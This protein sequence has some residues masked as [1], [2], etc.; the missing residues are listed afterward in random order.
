[1]PAGLRRR[2]VRGP[3]RRH[4]LPGGARDEGF[5]LV[6]VLV[7][8]ALMTITMTA[9]TTF[10][11]AT[12]QAANQQS[13][14]QV[15]AQLAQDAIEQAR[16]LKGS[17]IITGRAQ[18]GGTNTCATPVAGVAPYLADV[19]EWDHPSGTAQLPT[20]PKTVTLNGLGFTENWYVGRCWQA[21]AGGACLKAQSTGPTL[22]YRVIV[23]VAWSE[24][25]CAASA[26]SF[27]AS[28]LINSASASPLF[29]S[30]Q[31]AQPP[32]VNNPGDQTDE[33][34]IPVNL[35][36]T[37]NGGAPVISWSA[38]GLPPNVTLSQSGV[39]IG[40]P[41]TVGSYPVVVT[42]KDGF[43]LTGTAA[44]TWT[45]VAPLT[46]ATPGG[47]T[48]DAT[49]PVTP[50]QV[51]ASNGVAPYTWSATGLPGGLSVDSAGKIS[52]TPSTAGSYPV[53][54][55][56]RDAKGASASTGTITWTVAAKPT[57]TA[58]TNRSDRKS[59]PVTVNSAVSGGTGPFQWSISGQPS[60]LTINQNTGVISGTT[61]GT[62]GTYTVT[63]SVKDAF[64]TVSSTFTWTV[65]S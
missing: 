59:T 45:I 20:T 6:E 39:F 8:L 48:G 18:C 28:T 49:V 63:V 53:T 17:A 22:M 7:S 24:K 60:G 37:A 21:T 19:E 38:V 56:V 11:V 27:V 23:A 64:V 15:G 5:T 31:A 30:N 62:T 44:F 54:V 36:M 12:G 47:Q 16:A 50:L 25:H 55:T 26:C 1:M 35:T 51:V 46:V 42:A 61:P 58:P 57:I 52:G 34:N 14:R 32:V 2:A 33:K 29:N 13:G 65:T 3:W 41:S 40:S 4:P 9:L 43:N 10:F